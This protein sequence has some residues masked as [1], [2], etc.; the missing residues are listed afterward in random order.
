[1]RPLVPDS[2]R[3]RFGTAIQAHGHHSIF[4]FHEVIR[5]LRLELHGAAAMAPADRI[6]FQG[7]CFHASDNT[8][9]E[10]STR[11]VSFPRN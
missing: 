8:L 11:R 2:C 9:A 4:P 10:R 7:L 6:S 5:H 3:P 1:V